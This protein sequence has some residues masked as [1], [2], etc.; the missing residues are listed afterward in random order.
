MLFPKVKRSC[1]ER[2]FSFSAEIKVQTG[3]ISDFSDECIYAFFPV[4]EKNGNIIIN[5]R[6]NCRACA[7][8]Q[9]A[10]SIKINEENFVVT[11][12]ISAYSYKGFVRAVAAIKRMCIQNEIIIGE[13]EDFPSFNVRGYIEGF[14]GNPWKSEERLKMLEIMALFGENTHYYAPKDDPYHRDKWRENYPE[15]MAAKLKT[16]V[17][18]AKVFAVDFYYCIAPGLSMKYSCKEDLQ[19]LFNKTRQLFDM[20]ITHFGLLLDDIPTTL[21]YSE[22]KERFS[23]VAEAHAH[24]TLEYYKFLKGLS[25]DT[26]LT[27]CPTS[28]HGK[29]NEKELTDFVANLPEDISV[30]F[31]GSDICSKEIT[32]CEAEVF[33]KNT[34]RQPLYWDN[35]PVNDAEMFMEMHIGPIIGRE[36]ELFRHSKGIISNCMEYFNCNI[37][38]LITVAAYLWNPEEYEPETAFS[39][40][41]DYLL[42][43]D[44]RED[45]LLLADHFRT[46]CLN[47]ENSRIA[48]EYFSRVSVLFQTGNTEKAVETVREYAEKIH[49]A[50]QKLAN[51]TSPIYK[52]LTRWI[53][54]FRLMSEITDLAVE[55]LKGD[56]DKTR[57]YEK[58]SEYNESATVL[59]AFCFRE[60]IESVLNK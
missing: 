39:Y 10:Y 49:S 7:D 52:E 58:M 23:S 54:K 22:D 56:G 40:A 60:F 24:I 4:C 42:P 12:D 35:Y 3:E 15:D 38:P 29:G 46:S 34:N 18:K 9:E 50:S 14:Y 55:V 43:K 59:T 57:L 27:V 53:K 41:V 26:A 2:L 30:F 51:R 6:K 33:E 20:G 45:F 13:I 44:E 16:L 28:Y 37:I 11:C 25:Q 1:E 47:D 32:V 48:G 31:T 36:K 5:A 19:A 21:F 8:S 17:D